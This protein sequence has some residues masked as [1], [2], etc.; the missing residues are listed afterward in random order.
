MIIDFVRVKNIGCDVN[1]TLELY[2]YCK[3]VDNLFQANYKLQGKD[4]ESESIYIM[5]KWSQIIMV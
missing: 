1:S 5:S 2:M 3:Y 4:A